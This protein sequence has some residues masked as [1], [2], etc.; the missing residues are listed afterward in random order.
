MNA[1]LRAISGPLRAAIFRLGQEEVT[2]GRQ[3]SNHLCIGDVSVSR[4]HCV[5]RA[6]EAGYRINDLGSHNGTL[7]NAKPASE[8][9][10]KNADRVDIGGT[11]F[12]FLEDASDMLDSPIPVGDRETVAGVG[13]AE[14]I[15]SDGVGLSE[16][17]AG[18]NQ[19][20][21]RAIVRAV[22]KLLNP[23]RAPEDMEVRILEAIGSAVRAGEGR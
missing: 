3:P 10:L 21:E 2:V 16:D 4:L 1:A 7:V 14:S 11:V 5:I 12:E 15:Q 9:L 23:T 6:E 17:A 20:R 8:C 19:S 18:K 22:G 13:M